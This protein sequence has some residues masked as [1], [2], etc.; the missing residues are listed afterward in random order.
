MAQ[1]KYLDGAKHDLGNIAKYI[2]RESGSRDIALTYVSRI[3]AK[4]KNLAAAETSR[5]GTDR[6]ELIEGMRSEPF[7]NY[8][9]FFRYFENSLE[10]VNILEGHRDIA[11]HFSSEKN[12]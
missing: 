2:A 3:R 12:T 9:I 5:R 11:A 10:V 1:L 8:V 6:S 7:G 4:C